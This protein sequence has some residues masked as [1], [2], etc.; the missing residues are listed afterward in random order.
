MRSSAV[1][2]QCEQTRSVEPPNFFSVA[3]CSQR[4]RPE[5]WQRKNATL[6]V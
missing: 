5:S 3:H 4:G 6:S 2:P 1:A